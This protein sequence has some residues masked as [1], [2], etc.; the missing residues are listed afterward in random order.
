M[1]H[2]GLGLCRQEGPRPCSRPEQRLRAETIP[3][4][5]RSPT[6]SIDEQER[7]NPLYSVDNTVTPTLAPVHEDLTVALRPEHVA[8]T[9]ELGPQLLEVVDLSVVDA[10]Y[11]SVFVP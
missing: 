10:G 11:R 1:G 9:L 5:K 2:K 7:K 3:H 4:R 6:S 8:R